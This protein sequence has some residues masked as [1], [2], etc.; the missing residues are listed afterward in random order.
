MGDVINILIRSAWKMYPP[1]ATV[2]F[3]EGGAGK[4]RT[5]GGECMSFQQGFLSVSVCWPS[6]VDCLLSIIYEALRHP[7]FF[8]Y[9]FDQTAVKKGGMVSSWYEGDTV[10]NLL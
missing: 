4:G 2:I 6:R 5:C 3:R 9:C 10:V 1:G 8:P 7:Q